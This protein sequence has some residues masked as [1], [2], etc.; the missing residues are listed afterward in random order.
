MY[1]VLKFVKICSLI[2][3]CE[4]ILERNMGVR[5][6]KKEQPLRMWSLLFK[7]LSGPLTSNNDRPLI[8]NTH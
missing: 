6:I 8:K 5:S 4:N 2:P 7:N 1:V 3:G